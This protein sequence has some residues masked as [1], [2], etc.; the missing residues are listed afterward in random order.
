MDKLKKKKVKK[1]GAGFIWRYIGRHWFAYIVGLV[2]LFVVD[3]VNLFVPQFTGEITDGLTYGSLDKGGILRLVLMILGCGAIIMLGRFLWRYTLFGACRKI[4]YEIRVDLYAHLSTQSANFFNNNKTGDLMSYFTNDLGAIRQA[5]GMAVI[6]AFDASVM[7]IMVLIKMAV[8]VDVPLTLISIIPLVFILFG[9]AFYGKLVEKRFDEKQEAFSKMSD[10]VQESISGIR[11][12]KAFVQEKKELDAFA[13]INAFNKKKNMRVV[14]LMAVV[15]S[16]LELLIGSACVLALFF[17]G[18]LV[19][20]GGLTPGKFVAFMQYLM[21]LVW[22]MIA[23]GNTITSFS[24]GLASMKRIGALFNEQTDVWDT[25]KTDKSI[26]SLKGQIS[27]KNLTFKYREELPTVLDKVTVDVPKGTS[28]AIIGRTGSG[29]STIA[30]LLLHLYNVEDGQI[31]LDGQDINTIPLYTLRKHI[32]YVPQDN[33]LFS[34]TLQSNIA[35]GARE[36]RELPKNKKIEKKIILSKEEELEAY[37]EAELAKRESLAD[38]VYDDLDKV[39]AAAKAACIHD[40]IVEF[41]K[42]YAT[43]VGERGVTVSGGQ[44]Q[45][46]SIARALMK[47]APILILDDSLSAVDTDTEESILGNLKKLRAGKTTI[48]IA[49]RISTIENC[50][51][52]LVLDEGKVAEYGTHEELVAKGGMYA[53]LYEKQLLE[54]SEGGAE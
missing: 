26:S 15:G 34:D 32:A 6:S 38:K 46:S 48:I 49:H 12:I 17:G 44:K 31:F 9:G 13:K 40:N 29:K 39:E 41:P 53:D 28:L 51:K 11:V 4:E 19:M 52:I 33:F 10:Q 20:D 37:L 36:Y 22:P 30:N 24:Q 5:V 8:Y 2:T 21:M 23:M 54:E 25:E 1:K 14:G 47:D 27:L 35:F 42:G 18:K 16:L 43:M 50:D 45:R 7:A 3:Y